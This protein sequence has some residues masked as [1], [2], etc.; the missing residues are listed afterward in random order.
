M[1]GKDTFAQFLRSGRKSNQEL[2]W[3]EL[4]IGYRTR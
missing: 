1:H 2:L 4:T 3:S